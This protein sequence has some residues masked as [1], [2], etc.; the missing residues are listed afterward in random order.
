[1]SPSPRTSWVREQVRACERPTFPKYDSRPL[2]VLP[3]VGLRQAQRI[4]RTILFIACKCVKGGWA[5][6]FVS[7][8]PGGEYHTD[9]NQGEK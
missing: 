4:R 2:S 9:R 3:V 1:M 5:G 8:T 6:R 7:V